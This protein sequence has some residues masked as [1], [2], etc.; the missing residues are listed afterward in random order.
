MIQIE[1]CLRCGKP[2][3]VEAMAGLKI[4]CDPASLDAQTAVQALV[5]G[6]SVW[7]VRLDRENRPC[8]L[9]GA[10][11]ALLGGLAG[12]RTSAGRPMLVAEHRCSGTAQAGSQSLPTPK[13]APEPTPCPK[14]PEKPVQRAARGNPAERVTVR[15]SEPRPL[16]DTCGQPCTPGTYMAVQIGDRTVWAQHADGCPWEG[17]RR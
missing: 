11:P 13:V 6:R 3:F 8:A 2:L 10:T 16:C 15:R 17:D 7:A 14:G 4:K 9:M 1:T 5:G 12:P